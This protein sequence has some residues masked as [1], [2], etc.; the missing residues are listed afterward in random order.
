VNLLYGRS[1]TRPNTRNS[2]AASGIPRGACLVL[3]EDEHPTPLS[4]TLSL[5]VFH[6][7][8]HPQGDFY[9]YREKSP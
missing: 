9:H 8:E 7:L 5:E 4:T 3:E 2:P 1:L 6:Y